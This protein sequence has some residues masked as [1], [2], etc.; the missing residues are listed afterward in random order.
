MNKRYVIRNRMME[1]HLYCLAYK[2]DTEDN[3]KIKIAI[4]D[5]DVAVCTCFIPQSAKLIALE[6]DP[7]D[8]EYLYCLDDEEKLQHLQ[9]T[10]EGKLIPDKF[11]DLSV[12]QVETLIESFK[13]GSWDSIL[14][15]NRSVTIKGYTFS[16]NT[17]FSYQFKRKRKEKTWHRSVGKRKEILL[18]QQQI[19]GTL[20]GL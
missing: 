13:E 9:I 1:D 5:N 8:N 18:S 6:M 15:D 10:V 2:S 14:I 20:L 3:K 19:P 11:F 7:E 4:Q 17:N 12:H 16:L